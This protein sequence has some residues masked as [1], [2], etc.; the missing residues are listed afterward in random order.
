MARTLISAAV[1]GAVGVLY[2][3]LALGPVVR[4]HAHLTPWRMAWRFVARLIAVAVILAGLIASGANPLP[5]AVALMAG[6]TV[7]AWWLVRGALR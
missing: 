1:G 3:S 4:L 6:F 7:R 5:L 2:A